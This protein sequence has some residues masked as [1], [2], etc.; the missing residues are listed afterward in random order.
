MNILV[1]SVFQ[2]FST[3]LF[4]LSTAACAAEEP[5][6]EKEIVR[7]V[8]LVTIGAE[9][10]EKTERFPAVIDA[11]QSVELSFQVGGQITS[12]PIK[13]GETIQEGALVAQLDDRDFRSRLASAKATHAAA[14]DQYLR[15]QRL[16]AADAIAKSELEQRLTQRDVA[17]AN[18]EE[19]RK[20]LK[21]TVLRAPFTATVV[22]VPAKQQQHIQAGEI[23]AKL[24]G[25]GKTFEAKINVPASLIA[26]SIKRK[27]HGAYVILDALPDAR[28][29]ASFTSALLMADAQ[30]QTYEV[31][32]VFEAPDNVLILPGMNAAVELVSSRLDDDVPR[33]S[34]PLAAVSSDGDA[35]YVWV[36][37]PDSMIAAKRRV[38]LG[39]SIGDS[40]VV[41]E[42]LTAG[43]VIAGAGAAYL[44]EGMR[45]RPWHGKSANPAN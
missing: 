35:R 41:T 8:K 14:Q 42:G 38:V 25:K 29:K 39:N 31:T 3:V 32:L 11:A 45:V 44:A 19:E 34:V 40:I 12:L 9:Q 2:K 13:E 24:M 20:A 15:A 43:E 28:M 6:P 22:S 1:R 27:E 23:V 10:T 17:R 5:Q 16:A 4:V 26:G 36:I 37:D 21:D 18:L 30:S 7:P 33:L